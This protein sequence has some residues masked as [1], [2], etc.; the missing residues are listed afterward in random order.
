[1]KFRR[2]LLG[3]RSKARRGGG[4]G[5]SGDSAGA[6]AI[7]IGR[8]CH[9]LKRSTRGSSPGKF[10]SLRASEVTPTLP[11]PD[12]VKHCQTLS[13]IVKHYQT[14]SNLAKQHLFCI[15]APRPLRPG[16]ALAP[17]RP[18]GL[19]TSPCEHERLRQLTMQTCSVFFW[20]KQPANSEEV[21]ALADL[22][23]LRL[24]HTSIASPPQWARFEYSMQL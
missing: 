23:V 18:S 10:P 20:G 24:R 1:M 2:R 7:A 12:I 16:C 15:Q 14:L 6:I 11:K 8:F 13:K 19:C 22:S 4:A 5:E 9:E 3:S 21:V 17:F